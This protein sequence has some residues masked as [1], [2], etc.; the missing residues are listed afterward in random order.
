M[1]CAA[2]LSSSHEKVNKTW[3]Q[4]WFGAEFRLLGNI[5]CFM[6]SSFWLRSVELQFPSSAGRF[7]ILG[8]MMAS[9]MMNSFSKQAV[10]VQPACSS[11]GFDAAAWFLWRSHKGI[12]G[13][14]AGLVFRV[15]NGFLKASLLSWGDWSN[16]T[17]L[18]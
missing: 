10:S 6:G 2:A 13:Y 8:F 16:P 12:M 9:G 5:S 14:V 1:P 17:Y 11:T 15:I 3:Y 7:T 18:L 4:V